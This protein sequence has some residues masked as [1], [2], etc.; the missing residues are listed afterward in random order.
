MSEKS[1]WTFEKSTL[2]EDLR[3]F[4]VRKDLFRHGDQQFVASIL[5]A[6][7]SANVV[8]ITDHLEVVLVD[9]FRFGSRDRSLEIPGGMVDSGEEPLQAA[10]RELLEETGYSAKEWSYLGYCYSNPVFMDSKVHHFV[11]YQ[12]SPSTSPTP[13]PAEDIQIQLVP[14]ERIAVMAFQMIHH[15]H[16]LSALS[17]AI[18]LK[19][20]VQ[21]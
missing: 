14:V 15:P 17:R 13:E 21:L 9:I 10:Q 12:A 20:L 4:K 3:M 11:A 1:K 5:E 6:Q 19:P 7:D 18:Q 8:A 2:G 16:T